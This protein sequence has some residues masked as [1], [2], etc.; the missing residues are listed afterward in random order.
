MSNEP[1]YQALTLSHDITSDKGS[2]VL[3]NLIQAVPS[4][5]FTVG[6]GG[7]GG[8][9]LAF[10][11]GA[12]KPGQGAKNRQLETAILFDELFQMEKAG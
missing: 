9:A 6:T 12:W 5:G 10:V 7:A 4:V 8:A 3:S 2:R 1:Q 11:Q